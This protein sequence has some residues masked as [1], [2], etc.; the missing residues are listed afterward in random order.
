MVKF[1]HSV[2]ALPFALSGM[3]LAAARYGVSARQIV[4]VI[5]AMVAARNAAMGFNRLAD[6]RIDARNPRTEGRELPRGVIS[7]GAVIVFTAAL[8]ALFVVA[9]AQLNWLCATLAPVALAVAFGYSFTKRF[10]WASHL[11]LG[12]ALAMAPM[13]G[14]LAVA[15]RFDVAPF[16]LVAAV[17]FWVAGFDTIYA[18]QDVAFDRSE[19]LWSIPARFGVAKALGTARAFHAAAL[20]AMAGVGVAAHLHPVYWAGIAAIGLVLVWE[21]R[22]VRSDD[23]SKIGVAFL[24]ANGLISVL[25]LGVVLAALALRTTAP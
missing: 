14:W 4:W 18:C 24:N 13:G 11:V 23:L 8:S 3:V 1:S 15:G 2:F 12:V 20:F 9:A 5:V 16:W 22:M 10:T 7:R 17:V 19:G 25:Y 6:H 21:H